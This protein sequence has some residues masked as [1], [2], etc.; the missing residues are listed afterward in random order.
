MAMRASIRRIGSLGLPFALA[1]CVSYRA[2]PIDPRK[3]EASFAARSLADP[4]FISWARTELPPE[5]AFP[6]DRWGLRD[7]ALAAFWFHPDVEV[8]RADAA[9]ARAA[10][11]TASARP[12]P[13]LA[14]RPERVLNPDAGE[15][16]WIADVGIDLPIETNGK[17]DL[18]TERARKLALA[19]DVLV[20]E[21]A[22][23]V[24]SAV[25]ASLADLLFARREIELLEKEEAPRREAQAL[26]E[27]RLAAGE[28]SRPEVARAGIELAR[29]EVEL[30]AARTRESEGLAALASAIGVPAAAL[31]AASFGWEGL[32][33][34]PPESELDLARETGL[35]GRFDVRRQL[36]EYDAAELEVRLE[37]AR[38]VPDV[39]LGPGYVFD[40]GLRKLAFSFAIPLPLLDR[41]QGPIAEAEARRGAS[42]ARFLALQARASAETERA[43]ARYR[44]AL[45]ELAVARDL[46][47]RQRASGEAIERGFAAGAADRLDVAATRAETA[48]L[49]LVSLQAAQRTQRA[50]GDLESAV[51][52]PLSGEPAMLGSLPDK[53]TP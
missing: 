45:E 47:S 18:R 4:G 17:R 40:Q 5:R 23:G 14:F 1:G 24:R 22:W 35:L 11:R 53:G 6:P 9:T 33:E 16:A 29:L 30:R 25:R 31:A 38:Q 12:N 52:R 20:Y 32:E 2:A 3:S 26:L 15:S 48:A 41:N 43:L 42:Q 7:L 49:A 8:A 36:L 46:E 51:Q 19:A 50:L 28:S 13:T 34:P 27:A 44:G 39:A 10:V 21:T 37:V